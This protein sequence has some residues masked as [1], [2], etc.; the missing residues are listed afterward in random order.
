MKK[1]SHKQITSKGGNTTLARHGIEH[2]K[3][4]GKKG[5]ETV[6]QKYGPDYY[7]KLSQA[8]MK[9]RIAKYNEKQKMLLTKQVVA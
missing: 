7:K 2:F 3:K 4:I 9:A 8:G 6:L 5:S 1:L